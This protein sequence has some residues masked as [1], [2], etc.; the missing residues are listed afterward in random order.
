[1]VDLGGKP[2]IVWSIESANAARCVDELVV[3]TDDPEIADVAR[4]YGGPVPFLRPAHL[5]ADDTPDWPV[6]AHAVEWLRTRDGTT[7]ETVV[8]LR[9]TVP[10]R[11]PTDIE[12]CVAELRS[13]GASAVRTLV[14]AR[15]HPYWSVRLEQGR[16]T[17]F[18][19]GL[20]LAKYPR[21]QALPP[22]YHPAGAVE[23]IRTE[24]ALRNGGLYEGEVRGIVI[25]PGRAVDIDSPFDLEVA[26]A[27]VA[28]NGLR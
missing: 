5:A 15:Q 24:N 22:V 16:V 28:A 10:F 7:P 8:W 17:P 26:R 25:P 14:E 12:A 13:S 1:V 2:L 9:P 19:D 4:R 18:I 6:F 21:R 27:L 11:V 3:S 23:A 20:Q